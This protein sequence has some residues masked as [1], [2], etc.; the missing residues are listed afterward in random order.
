MRFPERRIAIVEAGSEGLI[1]ATSYAGCAKA[2]PQPQSKNR[3]ALIVNKDTEIGLSM[4]RMQE[5]GVGLVAC[6]L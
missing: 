3:I 2:N 6:S 4:F 5:S 1:D